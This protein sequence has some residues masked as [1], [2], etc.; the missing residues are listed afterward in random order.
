[1]PQTTLVLSIQIN[2]LR[3]DASKKQLAVLPRTLSYA[4]MATLNRLVVSRHL[5]LV[6]RHVMMSAASATKPVM[7]LQDLYARITSLALAIELV[8]TQIYCPS[9]KVAAVLLE[10]A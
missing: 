1:M 10:L 5:V 3:A 9:S 6:K 8:L 4:T 2:I 7:D